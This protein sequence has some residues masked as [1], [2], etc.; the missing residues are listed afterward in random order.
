MDTEEFKVRFL[1]LHPQLYRAAYALMRNAEDA[2]D[3]V[4][5]AYLKLW[6]KRDEL[7]IRS[8]TAAYCVSLVRR[9]C[10]DQLQTKRYTAEEPLDENFSRPSDWDTEQ[11]LEERDCQACLKRL[12]D[13]LPDTPRRVLWLR[14]V[15][16]CSM[17]EITQATGLTEVNIRSI[18]SRTRKKI[19]EQF[20][21]LT[22]GD[23]Q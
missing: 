12:I 13:R 17:Q 8:N 23:R 4:Q 20:N 15:Q 5:E 11:R 19:R 9:L 14:D 3:I 10:F 16:E 22:G 6:S 21:Q 18:L 1:P 7:D 2:E